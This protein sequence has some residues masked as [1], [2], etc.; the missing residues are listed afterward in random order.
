L[1]NTCQAAPRATGQVQGDPDLRH[2]RSRSTTTA[3][4]SEQ[5]LYFQFLFA[6]DR[7]KALAPQHP[8][9]KSKEPF[10][11]VLAGDVR[12]ALA[13]GKPALMTLL[14]ETHS[15]MTT[16]EFETVV[17]QWITTARHPK[18]GRLY[19]EMAYKPMLELLAGLNG[20]ADR[21]PKA[22][23]PQPSSVRATW[24]PRGTTRTPEA[25]PAAPATRW[26]DFSRYCGVM[27]APM[28]FPSA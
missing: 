5:P 7:V 22:A 24:R 28:T 27:R 18:T 19:T 15:G 1:N 26:R 4:W 2:A 14:A 13:G 16:E 10:K 20:A 21:L 23:R 12:A 11:S 6:I 17:R 3:P 8:D 9:W 25:L